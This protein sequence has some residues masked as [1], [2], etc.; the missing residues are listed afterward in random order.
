[1]GL[2]I[3]VVEGPMSGSQNAAGMFTLPPN[4]DQ[5]LHAAK[6]VEEAAVPWAKQREPIVG[7]N[8][9]ADGWEVWKASSEEGAKA[10]PTIVSDG[11]G[12]KYTLMFRSKAVQDQVNALYGNVSKGLI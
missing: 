6:W 3:Q 2:G 9:S 8:L 1:M 12:R 11:K 5:K 4:F 10:K 7:T